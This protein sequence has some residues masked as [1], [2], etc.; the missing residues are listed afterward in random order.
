MTRPRSD[1]EICLIW[2]RGANSRYASLRRVSSLSSSTT[3]APSR[4]SFEPHT[5][6]PY[7]SRSPSLPPHFPVLRPRSFPK[8]PKPPTLSNTSLPLASCQ[9][10]PPH[11]F[12]PLRPPSLISP[13]YNI[14]LDHPCPPHALSASTHTH[15]RL[16]LPHH[17][18][19]TIDNRHTS[20]SKPQ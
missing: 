12:W 10:A 3:S 16:I 4:C 9:T 11:S 15:P 1:F 14:P 2:K 13:L 8:S 20:K 5:P 18:H 19:T 6:L 17:Q 7:L